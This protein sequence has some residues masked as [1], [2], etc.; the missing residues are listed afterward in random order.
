VLADLYHSEITFAPSFDPLNM[1]YKTI[2]SPDVT[3]LNVLPAAEDTDITVTVNGNS[4]AT[5]V[6]LNGASNDITI[7]L[8]DA[9]GCS[10]TRYLLRV[11]RSPNYMIYVNDNSPCSPGA[12]DGETWST[13]WKDLQDA[14]DNAALTGREIWVAEGTYKPIARTD[15]ADPRS[16]TFMVR[17]GVEI[18][19]SFY[20]NET[21]KVPTGSP[22]STVLTGD[23]RGNDDSITVFPPVASVKRFLNDNSYHVVTLSG[24]GKRSIKLMGFTMM[25]GA[26]TG[27]DQRSR[28]A[29][30]YNKSCTPEMELCIFTK[31]YADSGG[32]GLL[33]IGGIKKLTNCLFEN[34]VTARGNGAGLS[35]V[36]SNLTIDASVFNQ[37]STQDT[38][39]TTGGGAMYA[40]ESSLLIT[41][42][43]FTG[44]HAIKGGGSLFCKGVT[45]DMASCTM[46]GNTTDTGAASLRTTLSNCAVRNTI[47]WNSSAATQVTG[48]GFS[49]RY[50]CIQGGYSGTANINVNPMFTNSTNPT[51]ADTHFGTMDDGLQLQA[52]SP[53]KDAGIDDTTLHYDILKRTRISDANIDIGA[54]E[55]F[56]ASK[57]NKVFFGCFIDGQFIENDSLEIITLIKHPKQILQYSR[58]NYHRVARAYIEKN[59]GTESKQFMTAYVQPADSMGNPLAPVVQ[60]TL[61]KIGVEDGLLVFQTIAPDYSWGKRIIFVDELYWHG[62]QNPW[63]YVIYATPDFN[64]SYSVPIRQFIGR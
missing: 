4:P 43:I 49:I 16:A 17:S 8:T 35:T 61:K 11:Q 19:G 5:P 64:L 6:N 57:L 50:C 1:F 42:S 3:T 13:A 47:L 59:K 33:D 48:T 29:G 15:A 12:E 20:G 60:F 52:G 26:A 39:I 25:R 44:N 14:L 45:M 51:G 56:N 37:N 7:L 58:S 28:G 62:V 23:L 18:I 10:A 36:R 55:Y 63:A 32:A 30:L 54:Y 2:I 53:C 21:E 9:S 40:E 34:N 22:Y 24:T 41:N 31:N 38:F 46:Y 27:S